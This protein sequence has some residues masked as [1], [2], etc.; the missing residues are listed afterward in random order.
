MAAAS[1]GDVGGEPVIRGYEVSGPVG[2]GASGTT[3][4]VRGQDGRPWVASIVRRDARLGRLRLLRDLHHPHLPAIHDMVEVGDG[5][6]AVVMDLVVG[7]SLATLVNARSWLRGPEVVTVWRAIADALAAMHQRGLVHGDVS[8]ANIIIGPDGRPVLIDVVGHGGAERGH[9]G[10]VPPELDDGDATTAS[11]VWS[12]ARTLSWASGE[13]RGVLAAL[14][15]AL[16]DAP[17]RR[18]SA[19]DFATWAFVLGTPGNIDVPGAA[20]LAGAQL[21]AGARQT[22]LTP[23]RPRPRLRGGLVWPLVAALTAVLGVIGGFALLS[24]TAA[25]EARPEATPRAIRAFPPVPA[26]RA[27]AVTRELLARRDRVL[28]ERDAT[29]LVSVY[30]PDAEAGRTDAALVA[31]M[32]A[33]DTA[34]TGYG[35]EVG[36]FELVESSYRGFVARLEVRQLEHVRVTRGAAVTVPAQQSHCAEVEVRGGP[37]LRIAAV[38]GCG[39]P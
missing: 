10:Y 39:I 4:G 31:G 36:S 7:P 27:E 34:F 28:V 30:A 25:A 17:A 3:L 2:F 9:T 33:E 16:A 5:E 23:S 11:D 19:R 35:T 26:D 13:D 12:L 6:A 15:D 29:A 38:R 22:V 32:L 37:D 14:G 8:P 24:A 20:S 18:P 1:V 21:R